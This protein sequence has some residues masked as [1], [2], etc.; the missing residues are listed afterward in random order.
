MVTQET[1]N[2]AKQCLVDNGIGQGEA[3][4]VL[5]ALCYILMDEE[6][7]QFMS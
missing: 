6:T 2:R 7:E 5:N 3:E 4:T 1:F